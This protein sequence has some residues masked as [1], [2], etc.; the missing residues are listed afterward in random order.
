KGLYDDESVLDELQR[1]RNAYLQS[2][3]DEKLDLRE[4][5]VDLQDSI[6]DRQI[7]NYESQKDNRAFKLSLWKPFDF[8]VTE[9]FDPEWMFGVDRFDL[10]IGNPPYIKE[11][12]R[13]AAFDHIRGEKY[14]QGK[15]D[16]WYYFA[17][18][19]LDKFV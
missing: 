5:F 2:C 18:H 3:G 17:C 6:F 19:F 4:E 8:G 9:W 12:T 7:A 16:I 1:I 14:Y 15:M 10:V 13:R 11:Y